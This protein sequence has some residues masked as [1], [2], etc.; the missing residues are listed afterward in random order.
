MKIKALFEK[1]IDRHI[2]PAV[3][4]SELEEKFIQQEIDEYIFTPEITRGLHKYL[5]AIVNKKQGKTGVWVSGYYGSGKSHFIKYIYYCLHPKYRER[6]LNK[7]RESIKNLD[8]LETDVTP[9]SVA[10]IYRSLTKKRF[11]TILFNIDAISKNAKKGNT[12]TEVFLNKLNEHRGFNNQNVALALYLEKPLQKAGKFE[13]FQNEI[14]S[15]LNMPWR[16]NQQNLSFVHMGKV[17][18]IAGKMYPELDK[19]S[20]RDVVTNRR[21][22]YSIN[23][24][25]DEINDFLSTQDENYR[26]LFLVDEISQYIGDNQNLLLNLETIVEE[27]GAK[28]NNQV[29]ITCTAQQELPEVINNT[30]NATGA[31]GKIMG[32]FETRISLESLDASKIT[33]HRVLEKAPQGEERLSEF[34]KTNK[35]DV[36]NQFVT[37]SPLY[38]GFVD[39]DDFVLSYP[40]IPYQFQ[41]ISDVF[42][43]FAYNDFV[44]E[45]VKNTERS[46]IGITHATAKLCKENEEGYFVPFDL[47]LNNS[48][49]ERLKNRALNI[50]K[51]A[52][53]LTEHDAFAQRVVKIL[54][55]IANLKEDIAVSFPANA[56]NVALLLIESIEDS[57]SELQNR[58][59]DVLHKLEKENII[60]YKNGIY[61][62]FKEEEIEVAKRIKSVNIG[63]EDIWSVFYDF[64]LKPVLKPDNK[65]SLSGNVFKASINVDDKQ[66]ITKGAF[67]IN[68]LLLYEKSLAQTAHEQAKKAL[69]ISFKAW[70]SNNKDKFHEFIKTQ[71]FISNNYS[72][73]SDSMKSTIDA[74]YEANAALQTELQTSLTDYFNQTDFI[75]AQHVYSAAEF[76]ISKPAERLKAYVD[77]HLGNIY[78]KIHLADPYAAKT[79]DI[80]NTIKNT[81]LSTNADLSPAEEQVDNFLNQLGESVPLNDVID[82]FEKQPYG[83]NLYA[84]IDVLINLAQK[85]KREFEYNN[86]EISL[87]EFA[88]KAINRRERAM[89][90]IISKRQIDPQKIKQFV[91]TVNEDIFLKQVVSPGREPKNIV[92]DFKDAV[93]TKTEAINQLKNS[94]SDFPFAEHLDNY[95]NTLNAIALKRDTAESMEAVIQKKSELKQ[96]QDLYGQID[97]FTDKQLQH[98][99]KIRKFCIDNK[100]NFGQLNQ[101]DQTEAEKLDDF[102]FR[103]KTPW[104]ELPLFIKRM[105][106]LNKT[107]EHML[108]E[109]REKLIKKFNAVFDELEDKQE[110]L[111]LETNIL[112]S[113]DYYNELIEKNSNI[114]S[115]KLMF[116]TAEDMKIEFLKK[117][118]AEKEQESKNK[119][120]EYVVSTPV[121]L[122]SE[123]EPRTIT[124]DAE[125]KA[126]LEEL[127]SMLKAKLKKHRKLYLN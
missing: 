19:E 93:K 110:T 48:F 71:T 41:L 122:A 88:D 30:G 112:P 27:V 15:A 113:R 43:S 96:L 35:V 111:V 16:G 73:F 82:K 80:Y 84:C 117:L 119:G 2:N 57:K 78:N 125:L 5:D 97:E 69:A 32:R 45:E 98:Y 14:Q 109:T 92:N 87:K 9:A 95:L 66:L 108:K 86:E 1:D 22:D 47:Y 120:D 10:N 127:E 74:F 54:F 126:Y 85:G 63:Q 29:W 91:E 64:I 77:K 65:Y 51:R 34:Y 59:E 17:L 81:Q 60:Q 99:V 114:T 115:L 50:L 106:A 25:I 7:F 101:D 24:L 4:V 44:D 23:E 36:E 105:K 76:N 83:W 79:E 37:D 89:L 100:Q 124:S 104:D 21:Q 94:C 18:D 62:F 103:H 58:V 70:Y 107:I 68:F 67:D 42:Q 28:C 20:I 13:A 8:D 46:I 123:L 53:T 56:E 118:E 38:K 55:M 26:L 40:F 6:A 121:Q 75:S 3:V 116:H 52:L 90:T 102:A 11:D 61:K 33:K 72:S 39:K 31:F 12:I 49:R